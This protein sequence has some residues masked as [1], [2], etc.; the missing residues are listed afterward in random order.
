MPNL[1]LEMGHG[2]KT[3]PTLTWD[4]PNLDLGHAQAGP[5]KCPTWSMAHGPDAGTW[6]MEP[7]EETWLMEPGAGTWLSEPGA[8][9][10]LME[11]GTGTRVMEPGA[12]TWPNGRAG[13]R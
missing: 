8:G 1:D 11:L 4:M 3:W 12:G 6:L 5:G 13:G 10:R 7:G 9:T 2:Q